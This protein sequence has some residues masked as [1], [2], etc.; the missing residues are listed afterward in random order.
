MIVASTTTTMTCQCTLPAGTRQSGRVMSA[1]NDDIADDGAEAGSSSVEFAM[2]VSTTLTSFTETWSTADDL[3][4]NDVKENISVLVT[5]GFI[6]MLTVVG[7]LLSFYADE[8]DEKYSKVKEVTLAS[9]AIK[10]KKTRNT[11]KSNVEKDI[12]TIEKSLPVAFGSQPFS[13]RF[14][15]ESK[16]YHKWVGV[17]FHYSHHFPRPLRVL[18]LAITIVS[19]LFMQAV[20][21]KVAEPDDGSC[22]LHVTNDTCLQERSTLVRTAHK[23]YWDVDQ[24]TCH[25]LEPSNDL[26]RV[27]YVAVISAAL[28]APISLFVDFLIIRVLTAKTCG[29]SEVDAEHNQVAPHDSIL[30]QAQL[31]SHLGNQQMM[32]SRV[33]FKNTVNE[34]F[35]SMQKQIKEYRSTL[36]GADLTEFD[37]KIY[38]ASD[39]LFF[40]LHTANLL[41]HYSY[42]AD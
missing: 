1:T 23:C 37:G 36:Y 25:F 31:R 35:G 39:L 24:S 12:L 40:F 10:T 18:S 38:S 5:L 30:P 20:M 9:T 17:V 33:L 6:G 2:V 34:E 29:S 41:I 19:L 15:S 13:Q 22:E 8:K 7:V 16:K 28:S 42:L 11:I 4:L 3:T 26:M 32:M 14:I 27:I 21:Y